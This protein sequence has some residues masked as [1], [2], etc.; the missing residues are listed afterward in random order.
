LI[1]APGCSYRAAALFAHDFA[2]VLLFACFSLRETRTGMKQPVFHRVFSCYVSSLP[3]SRS[4]GRL[5]LLRCVTCRR[6]GAQASCG[7]ARP[8]GECQL[9]RV[10]KGEF[11]PRPDYSRTGTT[12]LHSI[13]A[14]A[15][16]RF[17]EG[18]G[19]EICMTPCFASKV[20]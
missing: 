18:N 13:I 11:R 16:D 19:W 9:A 5:W 12:E 14:S 7:R 6:N 15:L 17:S 10:D 2:A 8:A 3:S 1:D 4:N 20:S